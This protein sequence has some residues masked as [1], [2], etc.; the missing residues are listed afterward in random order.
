[1]L[2]ANVAPEEALAAA[3]LDLTEEKKLASLS[4]D[5]LDPRY[6]ELFRDNPTGAKY[7]EDDELEDETRRK[8]ALKYEIWL[9]EQLSRVQKRKEVEECKQITTTKQEESEKDAEIG[10]SDLEE[11]SREITLNPVGFGQTPS[12]SDKTDEMLLTTR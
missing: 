7:E 12:K 6:F 8:T 9:R 11:E 3:G 4:H 1:M 10:S 5:D 2:D